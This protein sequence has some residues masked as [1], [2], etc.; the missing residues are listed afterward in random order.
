WRVLLGAATTPADLTLASVLA[1]PADASTVY[2]RSFHTVYGSHDSGATWQTVGRPGFR[3]A[4][5]GIALAP[6][7]PATLYALG[8]NTPGL[9]GCAVV[10]SISRST[11]GGASWSKADTA[12]KGSKIVS[13]AVDPLDARTVYAQTSRGLMK[14]TD[15]GVTWSRSGK[16]TSG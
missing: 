13:L 12:L 10:E 14:S 5:A 16:S 15:G 9:T 3:C 6:S 8:S 1:H 11:D 7:D 2:T 4:I